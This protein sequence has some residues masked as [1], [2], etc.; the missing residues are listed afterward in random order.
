MKLYL[1]TDN[2]VQYRLYRKETDSRQFLQPDSYHPDHVFSSVIF[3]QMIRVISRNSKVTSCQEDLNELKKDLLKSGHCAEAINKLE[4]KAHTRALENKEPQSAQ[5]DKPSLVFSV[6]YFKEIG[7]LKKLVKGIEGDIINLCGDVRVIFAMRKHLSIGNTMVKN[8][9]LS[10]ASNTEDKDTGSQKCHNKRCKTDPALFAEDEVMVNGKICKLDFTLDCK[11]KNIIYLSK[12]Q[13]CEEYKN[14]YFGQ[15][16]Q[17]GNKRMNG[18]REKFKLD[19]NAFEK[20]AL[21]MHCYEQHPDKFDMKYFKIGF[22]KQVNPL[23]LD[24]EE[25]IIINEYKTNIWG[26]NRIK[27]KR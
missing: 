12:C 11:E 17:C 21:S 3:S 5:E 13:I 18:H 16:V 25:D 26:L 19:D 2:T 27:V 10:E 14:A 23:N 15:T 22:V 24:R 1:D 9:K 20:S 4:P 8:R 7:H 6:T